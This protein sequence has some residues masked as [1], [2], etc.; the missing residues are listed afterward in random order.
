MQNLN[1]YLSSI[2]PG[3]ISDTAKLVRLVADC[4]EQFNGSGE[5]GMESRKLPGRMENVCWY[6]PLL[7][8]IIERHGG[9]VCGSTRA[10]IQKWTLDI[11]TKTAICEKV[12]HRQLKPML[13]GFNVLPVA[14]KIVRLIISHK[15]DKRLKWNND[16]SVRVLIGKILSEKSVVKQTIAG[17]RKRFRLALDELLKKEGW[18][19][20][21]ENV[22]VPPST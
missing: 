12:S 19:K 8:F 1:K 10:E 7:T 4:W 20:K 17:R 9:I 21:R 22:Y 11:D 15:E 3:P 14:R 6:P 16:G 2:P 18:S 5:G 13:P